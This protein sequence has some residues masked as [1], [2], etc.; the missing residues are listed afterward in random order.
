[1]TPKPAPTG[2][3]AAGAF[4]VALDSG[5]V[6]GL[7]TTYRPGS[8]AVIDPA[9]LAIVNRIPT[10][11]KDPVYAVATSTELFVVGPGPLQGA[12]HEIAEDGAL[13]VFPVAGLATATGPAWSV[14][15]K[16]GGKPALIGRSLFL[17]SAKTG[18]V[19]EVDLDAR[20]LTHTIGVCPDN[21]LNTT[22]VA[23]HPAGLV[24]VCFNSDTLH[25]LDP[26]TRLVAAGPIDLKQ[27]PGGDLQGPIDL[28]VCD[29]VTFPDIVIAMSIAPLVAAV[30]S[31]TWTVSP[32]WFVGGTVNNRVTCGPSRVD[33]TSSLDNAVHVLDRASGAEV[34]TF[35]FSPGC[36]PWES[37]LAF[38]R[39]WVTLN[40]CGQV[41][42]IDL[43]DGAHVTLI[44]L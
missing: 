28:A 44:D 2:I 22:A 9:T 42:A 10:T 36:A 15:F 6:Y 3:A 18:E 12:D 29:D 11:G 26:S 32:R 13:D 31:R 16:G 25:V 4:V 14:R 23:A 17:G 34:D 1:M 40:G 43:K 30:D 21:E 39:A 41:G 38:G 19:F 8:I 5:A 7:E 27:D 37:A 24:V 20:A 33:L 35:E